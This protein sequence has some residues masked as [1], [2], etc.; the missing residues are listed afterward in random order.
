VASPPP[1]PADIEALRRRRDALK[2]ELE[3]ALA[4][5]VRR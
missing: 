5:E 1:P 3:H 4:D 2:A